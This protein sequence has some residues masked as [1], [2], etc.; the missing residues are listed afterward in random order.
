MTTCPT[1]GGPCTW[2]VVMVG[3]DPASAEYESLVKGEVVAAGWATPERIYFGR[4]MVRA[5]GHREI[6]VFT[7]EQPKGSFPVLVI[8]EKEDSK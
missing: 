8:K 2:R 5:V 3:G 4:G 7:Q 6:R 1:C